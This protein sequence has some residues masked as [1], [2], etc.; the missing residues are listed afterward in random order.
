MISGVDGDKGAQ[1]IRHKKSSCNGNASADAKLDDEIW[2]KSIMMCCTAV[3][4]AI[5]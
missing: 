5:F 4:M 1:G 2:N 3:G